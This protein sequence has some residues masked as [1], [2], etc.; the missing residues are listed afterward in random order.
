MVRLPVAPRVQCG[1]MFNLARPG[2]E[3]PF[4][5]D[6]YLSWMSPVVSPVFVTWAAW[7][8]LLYCGYYMVSS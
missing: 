1:C 4:P 5:L 7:V 8:V 6:C 3:S 2:A